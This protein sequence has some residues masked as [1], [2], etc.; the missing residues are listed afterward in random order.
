MPVPIRVRET[1]VCEHRGTA[2][3]WVTLRNYTYNCTLHGQEL[4]L[5]GPEFRIAYFFHVSASVRG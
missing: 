1:V 2:H 5:E 3:L 4:F